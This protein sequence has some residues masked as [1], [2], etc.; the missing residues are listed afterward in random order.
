MRKSKNRR[1]RVSMTWLAALLGIVVIASLT[2]AFNSKPIYHRVTLAEIESMA[3]V[4]DITQSTDDLSVTLDW[5]Y[6]DMSQ[7]IIAYTAYDAE[8]NPLLGS[9]LPDG[10]LELSEMWEGM[11]YANFGRE[12]LIRNP[13]AH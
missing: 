6:A 5:A 12:P 13:D 9:E 11:Q 4:L 1:L 7:I 10:S 2:Y 3:M 8:G